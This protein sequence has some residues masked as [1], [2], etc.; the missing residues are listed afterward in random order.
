MTSPS[1]P[2][3]GGPQV[4]RSVEDLRKAVGAARQAGKRIGFVPTMGALHAGHLSLVDLAV[5]QADTVIV[6]L[7][8]NPKQ[9]APHEDFDDYPRTEKQDLA[10]LART[11]TAYAFIP[12]AR[13]MYPE[14]FA[15]AVTIAGPGHGLETDFRP[16]FFGGV[17]TVVA[18]L[19]N[20]VQP[21]CA[22]FG[23]KDYQQLQVIRRLVRDLDFP[24]DIIPGETVRETDGLALSSRNRYLSAA[25]RKIASNFPALLKNA[26]ADLA[27]GARVGEVCDRAQ[28][29]ALEAGFSSVDYVA[30]CDPDSLA[31]L[32]RED[33]LTAPARLLAAVWLNRTRL[34]DNWAVPAPA[35]LK[36]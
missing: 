6:S 24:I 22:V 29:T 31:R 13:S 19:F 30:V 18:K 26:V 21:D 1:P 2:L 15:T 34:I 8:V 25:E 27:K 36:G 11:G 32:P 9:F 28:A 35:T 14:G 5:S 33:R 10:M 17:A 12:P 23:E 20:Q 3:A 16:D 7:F 4:L